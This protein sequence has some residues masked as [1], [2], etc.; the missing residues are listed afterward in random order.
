MHLKP[1][2]T[3]DKRLEVFIEQFPLGI[4]RALSAS[5]NVARPQKDVGRKLAFQDLKM[6]T[7]T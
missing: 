6:T 3:Y 1:L 5:P 4:Q 2:V 7:P